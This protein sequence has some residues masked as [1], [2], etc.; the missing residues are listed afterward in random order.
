M[1]PWREVVEAT[2]ERENAE[3]IDLMFCG[4]MVVVLATRYQG[5]YEG[6]R[7]AAMP[8][9]DLD[10]AAFGEDLAACAWWESNRSRVGVGNTPNDA[11]KDWYLKYLSRR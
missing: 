2:Y 9:T 3:D 7:F 8:R 10:S 11:L 5:G 6:G 1:F 4:P